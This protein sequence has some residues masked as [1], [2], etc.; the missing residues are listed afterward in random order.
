MSEENKPRIPEVGEY[1]RGCGTLIEIQQSEP[2]PPPP[3]D[4]I[5]EEITAR[6]EMRLNGET[7]KVFN[8]VWDFY[9]K[10]TSVKDAI[11]EAKEYAEKHHLGPDSDCEV[12]AIKSISRTRKRCV[13]R[14]NHY[15]QSF[16]FFETQPYGK[17][18]MPRDM[19]EVVWSSRNPQR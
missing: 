10:G 14:P 8:S 18:G 15:D 5:F 7:L 16:V 6:C 2:L 19:E 3:S 13:E 17:A 1:V 4:Y 11:R 12:V 9:G